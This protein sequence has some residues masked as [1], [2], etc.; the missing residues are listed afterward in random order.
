[1]RDDQDMLLMVKPVNSVELNLVERINYISNVCTHLFLHIFTHGKTFELTTD[2]A[3]SITS[4]NYS[5]QWTMPAT[6][7]HSAGATQSLLRQ[8]RYNTQ[9]PCSVHGK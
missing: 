1:M 5:W 2:T 4:N 3:Y 8:H 9:L 6:G 7:C